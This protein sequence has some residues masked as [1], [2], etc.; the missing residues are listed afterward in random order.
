MPDATSKSDS[1]FATIAPSLAFLCLHSEEGKKRQSVL[2]KA[3][4]LMTLGLSIEDSAVLVGSSVAS[5]KELQRISK[6]KETNSGKKR[7]AKE[8]PGRKKGR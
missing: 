7:T 4:F 8:T 1:H 6:K 5:I 2:A 3:E